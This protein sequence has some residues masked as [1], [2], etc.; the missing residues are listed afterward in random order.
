MFWGG[1]VPLL[2]N[3]KKEK[4]YIKCVIAKRIIANLFYITLESVDIIIFSEQF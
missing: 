2:I 4:K 1:S 3:I